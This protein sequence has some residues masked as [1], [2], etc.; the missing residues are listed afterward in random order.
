MSAR[1]NQPARYLLDT[2]I[3]SN[4]VHHPQGI[5]AE[6]IAA[7]GEAHIGTS[8]VVASELR[9]GAAQSPSQRLQE[10]VKAI[11][12]AIRI[13]DFAPPADQHY[14]N[15]RHTLTKAGQL[16]GPNDLLIAAHALALGC[17]V[18]TANVREFA[19]VPGLVCENWLR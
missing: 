17:I 12:E 15:I 4:L 5:V 14:A 3:L 19:R 8:I 18:V 2:N 13:W 9:F 7:V 6:R 1:K 11:L 10:Q 16:I